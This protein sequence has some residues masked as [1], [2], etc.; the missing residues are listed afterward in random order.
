MPARYGS[1]G[2]FY[3]LVLSR[4]GAPEKRKGEDLAGV[5]SGGDTSRCGILGEEGQAGYSLIICSGN[6]RGSRRSGMG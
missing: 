3:L 2:I 4:I 5:V 6:S 1:T